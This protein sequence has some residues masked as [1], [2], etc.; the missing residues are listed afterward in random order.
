M[1]TAP[2]IADISTV[3]FYFALPQTDANG[4]PDYTKPP[5][6]QTFTFQ[7]VKNNIGFSMSNGEAMFTE[8]PD[9]EDPYILRIVNGF[10][11]GTYRYGSVL[12]VKYTLE[13]GKE[14]WVTDILRVSGSS[15]NMEMIVGNWI[16]GLSYEE[17]LNHPRWIGQ[18]SIGYADD[19]IDVRIKKYTPDLVLHLNPLDKS[20]LEGDSIIFNYSVENYC[21]GQVTFS[22]EYNNR[23]IE[24]ILLTEDTHRLLFKKPGIYT[25]TLSAS[26]PCEQVA[27]ITAT[28]VV[29]KIIEQHKF[30]EQKYPNIMKRNARYRGHRESEKYLNNHQEQLFDIRNSFQD[31]TYIEEWK[32]RVVKEWFNGKESVSK[33]RNNQ[34]MVNNLTV[35]YL[36]SLE[37]KSNGERILKDDMIE[38]KQVYFEN[39]VNGIYDIKQKLQ[40]IDERLAE[41]ER[42]YKQHEDAYE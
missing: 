6:S 27:S 24:S 12:A 21:D 15:K 13:D 18:P 36:S 17:I 28:I 42:R 29:E 5:E 34:D 8:L 3:T 4:D 25:I 33:L 14:T 26:N 38:L 16:D 37:S 32:E 1:D 20:V 7:E 22:W 35:N 23:T 30:M 40:M 31:I 11:F 9:E 39:H 41:I 10:Y 2:V 19:Y